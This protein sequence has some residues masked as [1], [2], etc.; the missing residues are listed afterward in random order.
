METY[1]CKFCNKTMNI[2][3]KIKHNYSK[4]HL[5][6]ANYLIKEEIYHNINLKNVE[7]IIFDCG[8]RYKYEF[9]EICIK[10]KCE[11]NI[12]L[13]TTQKESYYK[14]PNYGYLVNGVLE[15]DEESE[16]ILQ[17]ITKKIYNKIHSVLD[18]KDVVEN[19]SIKLIADYD[20]KTLYHRLLQPRLVLESKLIK[21]IKKQ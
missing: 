6:L 1:Y 18:R 12:K 13:S 4:S 7:K 10:V 8:N 17:E 11:I 19:L 20:K 16:E 5:Y 14:L 21:H 15:K 3:S 9:N 2:N